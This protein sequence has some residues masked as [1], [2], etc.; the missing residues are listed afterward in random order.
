MAV[1][2]FANNAV[3]TLTA[4]IA[5][6]DL[7]LTVATGTGALFP[8]PT[9]GDWF[10]ATLIRLSDAALEIVKVTARSTDTLTIERAQ[11]STTALAF[12]TGDQVQLRITAAYLNDTAS[13]AG[14]LA[15]FAATTS[16]QLAGVL[17]DETGSGSVVFAT[18]PSLVAPLVLTGTAVTNLPVITAELLD[19]N[20]WTSTGWT[21]SWAAGWTHTVGNT[22]ALSTAHTVYSGAKYQI[23]YT[24]T[25][26]T[27]GSFTLSI[28]GRSTSAGITATGAFGPTTVSTAS[29][30][31][32]PTTD[33]NGTIALSEKVVQGVSTP[34]FTLKDSAGVTTAE[35]RGIAGALSNTFFGQNAGGY[36]TTGIG[37]IATGY[38]TLANNSTGNTNFAAGYAALQSNTTGTV[39]TACGAYSLYL[40]VTGEYNCAAGGNALRNNV[41]GGYNAAFGPYSLYS[42][43]TGSY[44]LGMGYSALYGITSGSSNL[45]IGA[46]SGQYIADGATPNTTGTGGVFLGGSTRAL[47]D[48]GTSETVIGYGAIGAGSNT[49]TIGGTSNTATVLQG[50]VT[51]ATSLGFRTGGGGAITQ[52]TS[53]STGV[54]LN[55]SCGQV[56]MHNAALNAGVAVSF[57]LTNSLVAATDV[58]TVGIGSGATAASYRAGIDATAAGS[59]VI[60]LH[61]YSA[62]NLSEAVVLN[63]VVIKAVAA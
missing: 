14:T 3:A 27:A 22:S 51:V 31:V 32:T 23:A 16:A 39:N 12:V 9:A 18:A 57:T 6:G 19:A 63:F 17:N 34:L 35:I 53:K 20:D 7:S 21:G 36:N 48:G 46:Y 37:N 58:V 38:N 2:L 54:T 40:N 43:T 24:V 62:G 52:A 61:N 47:A 4:G 25:G 10:N 41:S 59:C 45:G 56:T 5:A 13:K 29:L 55:K 33:F 44:N 1:R 26:R 8:S 42:N 11:E 30:T 15:Q 50:A 49:V 28:G 60:T